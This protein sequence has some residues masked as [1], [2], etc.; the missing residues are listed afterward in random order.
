MEKKEAKHLSKVLK[1]SAMSLG[2]CKQGIEEWQDYKSADELCEHYWDGIEF[3]IEHPGWPSNEWLVNN[4][5][6]ETLN[7]NGIFIDQTVREVNPPLAVF[8]GK[9]S[10]SVVADN[11]SAPEFYVRHNSNISI[12]AKD[13]A[14][15]HVN[16]YDNA[17]V[18]ITCDRFAKCYVYQ[19]GGTVKIL[20]G[21]GDVKVRDRRPENL[22]D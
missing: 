14:I 17:S 15:V 11:F 2:M 22:K 7:R 19:Y 6:L 4:I 20:N 3:I 8:N 12:N 16:V 1:A 9:C 10:G 18:E 13:A 21:D 5:G